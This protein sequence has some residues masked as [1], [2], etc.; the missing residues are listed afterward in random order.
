MGRRN[1]P[2]TKTSDFLRPRVLIASRFLDTGASYFAQRL[3]S[4][5]PNVRR[6][7]VTSRRRLSLRRLSAVI[8]TWGWRRSAIRRSRITSPV[9]LPN[10]YLRYL[11]C[12]GSVRETMMSNSVDDCEFGPLFTGYNRHLERGVSRHSVILL[13]SVL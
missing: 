4:A 11:Y 3:T 8:R 5:H 2:A 1:G 6:S 13:S 10:T 7:L 12:V 9:S